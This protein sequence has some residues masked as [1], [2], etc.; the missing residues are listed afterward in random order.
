MTSLTWLVNQAALDHSYELTP[1]LE[2]DI[3]RRLKI[4]KRDEVQLFLNDNK[5]DQNDWKLGCNWAIYTEIYTD[6]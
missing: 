4:R 1:H 3:K 5:K 6:I 2:F